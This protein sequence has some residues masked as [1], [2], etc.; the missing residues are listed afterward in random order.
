VPSLAYVLLGSSRVLV[1]GPEGSVSTVVAAAVLPLAAAGSGEA[2]ELASIL[3]LLV[4]CCFLFARLVRLGWIADYFSRPVLIGY[5]HGVA[6]P[7][8]AAAPERAAAAAPRR[9]RAGAGGARR[10]PRLV[11]RR[12]PDRT[13]V[14]R[15]APRARARGQE[16]LALGAA[17]AAAGFT[18]A[19]SIGG[20]GSR[21]AVNDTL[22]ARSQLS[23]VFAAATIVCILLFLTGPVQYLPTAVL[24]A[25]I[26]FAA[27][28]LLDRAAW[29]TLA[30]IDHVEVAIAAVTTGCVVIF[31]VLQALVVAVGLSVIDTVRRS[32]RPYDAVLGF[33]DSLGRYA[34]VSLHPSARITPGVLVY[35]LDDR[36]FFANANYVKGR[37]HE[38]IRAAPSETRWVVFDAEAVMHVDAT[39]MEALA[40]L[41]GELRRA[42]ITLAVTRLRRRM[43]DDFQLAGVTDSIGAQRFYSSVERAVAAFDP[44]T[45]ATREPPAS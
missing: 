18:Q 26:V 29:R 25:I 20:A 16:L 9:A 17:N 8:R 3:A 14:R 2:V 32:A 23:G 39:G 1:V 44:S 10:L 31:G 43:H 24:G 15:Q 45:P 22:G 37:I 4:A 41:A 40:D 38:A 11:R 21:T 13:L 35:R 12:D 33:V 19:F 28:G 27:I 34:D 6:D 36:L 5:M 30:R 42:R 7:V